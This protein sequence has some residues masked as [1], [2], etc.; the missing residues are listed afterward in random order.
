DDDYGAQNRKD[1][2]WSVTQAS[3]VEQRL[4][5]GLRPEQRAAENSEHPTARPARKAPSATDTPKISAEPTAIPRASTS[6]ASVN[7]SRECVFSICSS[8]RGIT[9]RPSTTTAITSPA[10]LIPAIAN[11]TPTPCVSLPPETKRIAERLQSSA[12]RECAAQG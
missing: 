1:D 3:R 4:A 6:T 8:A 10:T 2:E 11:T 9:H 5:W 12:I 7:N